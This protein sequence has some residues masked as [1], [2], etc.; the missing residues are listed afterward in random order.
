M[1]SQP[2]TPT[3][4]AE[5]RAH[6]ERASTARAQGVRLLR[7]RRDGRHYATSAT[8]PGTRYFVTLVSCTCPGF[9]H[10]G[11]CKHHSALVVA[12]L[13]QETAD[14]GDGFEPLAGETVPGPVIT[15]LAPGLGI[16]RITVPGTG[17]LL[18]W[19]RV[20]RYSIEAFDAADRFLGEYRGTDAH[21]RAADRV[22]RVAETRRAA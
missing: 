8:K 4:T 6:A 12:H 2:L 21:T 9:I 20:S 19:V 17:E 11:H 1:N 13:L 18:G 22:W 14:P 10:H 15:E 7:D 3:E 16:D 5:L